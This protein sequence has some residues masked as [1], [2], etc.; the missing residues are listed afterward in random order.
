ML[1]LWLLLSGLVQTGG[2]EGGLVLAVCEALELQQQ[3]CSGEAVPQMQI[4]V[5]QVNGL[6]VED[7]LQQAGVVPVLVPSV[8]ATSR[9]SIS[10]THEA[11]QLLD[12]VRSPEPH[13]PML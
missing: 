1:D 9:A 3:M 5:V 7:L 8:A 13:Q 2:L 11:L 12:Q 10:S 4:S 6:D